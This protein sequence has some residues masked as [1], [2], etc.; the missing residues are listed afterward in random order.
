MKTGYVLN[1]MTAIDW[2]HKLELGP[3]PGNSEHVVL[4]EAGIEECQF[5]I[6]DLS[7][8]PNSK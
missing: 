1:L 4:R 2:W 8:N 5:L 7:I 6:F 3:T